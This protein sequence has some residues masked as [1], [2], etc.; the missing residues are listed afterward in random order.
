LTERKYK[1]GQL[2]GPKDSNICLIL[3]EGDVRELNPLVEMFKTDPVTF[4]YIKEGN[5]GYQMRESMFGGSPAVLYKS[6]K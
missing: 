5:E 3:F 2:C 6:K 1:S 4:V